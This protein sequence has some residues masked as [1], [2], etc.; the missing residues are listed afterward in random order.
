MLRR[1]GVAGLLA[2]AERSTLVVG[3]VLLGETSVVQRQLTDGARPR[4]RG[5]LRPGPWMVLRRDWVGMRR[6]GWLTPTALLAVGAWLVARAVATGQP[7]ILPVGAVALHL[8]AAGWSTALRAQ[9]ETR[10]APPL[11]GWSPDGE[12]ARH[13]VL[14]LLAVVGTTL[15]AGAVAALA[16][17]EPSSAL[18]A[19]ALAPAL[20]GAAAWSAVRPPARISA[21][22]PQATLPLLVLWWLT[23]V[24][25]VVVTASVALWPGLTARSVVVAAAAG[26]G[27]LVASLLGVRGRP[28]G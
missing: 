12:A 3:G 19:T 22:L 26:A 23:P 9:A 17:G 2:Q 28:T 25:L 15:A 14:P 4:R 5:R 7:W 13:L 11:L 27:L 21:V 16:S 18:A 24:L 1:L 6:R 20:L 8:G 10:G